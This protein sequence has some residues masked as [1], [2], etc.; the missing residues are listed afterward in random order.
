VS[1]W[2]GDTSGIDRPELAAPPSAKPEPAAAMQNKP[3]LRP[4]DHGAAARK[5][6]AASRRNTQTGSAL[7]KKLFVVSGLY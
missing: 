5:P 4:A 7:A 3:A 6:A 1:S 2:Q